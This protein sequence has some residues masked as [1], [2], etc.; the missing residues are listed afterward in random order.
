MTTSRRNRA[1]SALLLAA[2]ALVTGCAAPYVAK[3][4]DSSIR[5]TAERWTTQAG[6]TLRWE[7]DDL[8]IADGNAFSAGLKPRRELAPALDALLNRAEKARAQMHRADGLLPP[9]PVHACIYR[10]VVVVRKTL[11]AGVPC[12]DNR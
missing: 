5:V 10:D 6:K 11:G 2:S 7:A 1:L 4:D 12:S 9:I 8:D 3:P